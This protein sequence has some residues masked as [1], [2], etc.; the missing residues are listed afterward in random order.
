MLY[1]LDHDTLKK[2]QYV[3][4]DASFLG[5]SRSV[6]LQCNRQ[7]GTPQ[8]RR[9]APHLILEGGKVYPDYLQFC[10]AGNQLFLISDRALEI[11]E[12][13]R[14]TGYSGYQLA[15]AETSIQGGGVD[16][17]PEY[18]CLNVSGRVDVDY[19]TM[20][21]KKKRVC[22]QCGQFEWSRMRLEPIIL[23]HTTWDGSDLCLVDSLQG[24]RVCSERAK[25]IIH[26]HKLTG[27][28]VKATRQ[29][30]TQILSI[31]IKGATESSDSMAGFS[32]KLSK[33]RKADCKS[34]KIIV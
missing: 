14:I 27:F 7:I 34:G 16:R 1:W 26:D 12:K 21:I 29:L 23:D 20:H 18:Y 28:S 30:F 8:Y 24:F 31:A 2:F 11:F 13:N 5:F 3:Y 25:Q 33:E 17:L 22:P 10:G 19:A 15:T 6:C 4:K 32:S 9:E